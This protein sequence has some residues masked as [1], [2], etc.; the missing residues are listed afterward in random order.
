MVELNVGCDLLTEAGFN[1]IASGCPNLTALSLTCER[2]AHFRYI[3]SRLC[4]DAALLPRLVRLAVRTGKYQQEDY[5][6]CCARLAQERPGLE[7]YDYRSKLVTDYTWCYDKF[8]LPALCR[9][10]GVL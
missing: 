9:H 1:H 8:A 6:Q 2:P 7:F 3:V 5:Q 10:A 4:A